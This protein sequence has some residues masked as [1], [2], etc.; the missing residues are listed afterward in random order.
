MDLANFC[1]LCGK[2]EDLLKDLNDENNIG[3]LK[4][5]KDL[6]QITV[7]EN[8]ELPTKVCIHC[9]EKLV[10]FQLFILECNKVQE[11][12]QSMCLT[13]I[14]VI[15]EESPSARKPP[16]NIKA[17]VKDES[18]AANEIE[19]FQTDDLIV[20]ASFYDAD[21]DGGFNTDCESDIISLSTLKQSETKSNQRENK[22]NGKINMYKCKNNTSLNINDY[23]KMSC[24]ECSK[25]FKNW[26]TFCYHAKNKHTQKA[27]A[28]C[29]CGYAVTSKTLLFEH[30]AEHQI[31]LDLKNETR[32][33]K[34][35]S[36][37]RTSDL[38][39]FVCDFCNRKHSS[40]YSLERHCQYKHNSKPSVYCACGVHINSKTT[41]YSHVDSH[42]KPDCIR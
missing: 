31:K 24:E 2:E 37:I 34:T 27:V 28:Y 42:R 41:M 20:E 3:I 23:V 7:T 16:H 39:K 10:S 19:T 18:V 14:G 12:F 15:K 33:E 26:Q 36:K 25:T 40:W 21:D 35:K 5:V 9:E 22:N 13:N 11:T 4:M 29:F 1:R 38:I 6:I 30:L 17:E 8:D 32:L